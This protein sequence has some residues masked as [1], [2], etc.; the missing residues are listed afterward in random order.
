MGKAPA[1]SRALSPAP[2]KTAAIGRRP[3]I[4]AFTREGARQRQ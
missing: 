4:N 1:T 3:S 2:M